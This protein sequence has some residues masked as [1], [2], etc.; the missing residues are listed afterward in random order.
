MNLRSFLVPDDS[1]KKLA[2]GAAVGA[3]ALILDLEDA[4]A[5][6]AKPW[7]ESWCGEYL[8]A[9]PEQRTSQLWVRI[10]P[11][12]IAASTTRSRRACRTRRDRHSEDRRSRRCCG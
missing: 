6:P 2:K 4:V 12:T 9:H 5:A 10:N 11:S 8:N 7:R 1:E 3:D